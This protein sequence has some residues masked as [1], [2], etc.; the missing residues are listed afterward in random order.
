MPATG[1]LP[2]MFFFSVMNVSFV[3]TEIEVMEGMGMVT[4]MLEKT[5]GA[6]GPVSIRIF[7]AGGTANGMLR[8]NI[9]YVRH[10]TLSCLTIAT[11]SNSQ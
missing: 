5:E 11:S 6:I 8:I 3:A 9:F 2:L 4:L 7:T 1:R 10:T